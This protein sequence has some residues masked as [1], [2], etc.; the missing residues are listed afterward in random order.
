MLDD[1]EFAKL[2]FDTRKTYVE[3]GIAEASRFIAERA[4]GWTPQKWRQFGAAAQQARQ[5]VSES[6]TAGET[7]KRY[8]GVAG[9][10][11]KDLPAIIGT[12]VVGLSPVLP[13]GNGGL[14]GQVPGETLGPALGRNIVGLA[15]SGAAMLSDAEQPMVKQIDTLKQQID[16]GEFLTHKKGF[17]GWM[18]EQNAAVREKQKAFYQNEDWADQNSLLGS[19]ENVKLMQDYL[20][21]RSPQ[22]W[23]ALQDNLLRTPFRAKLQADQQALEN[24]TKLGRALAPEARPLISEAADPAELLPGMLAVK[25]GV[26]IAT[27]GASAGSRA[28]D[29][30]KGIA[31]EMLGEQVSATIDNPYLSAAER[32]QVAKDSLAG[33]L[34]LMGVGAGAKAAVQ[35]LSPSTINSPPST[36]DPLSPNQTPAPTGTPQTPGAT[37]GAAPLAGAAGPVPSTLSRI[38]QESLVPDLPEDTGALTAEEVA[39]LEGQQGQ[40]VNG[41]ELSRQPSRVPA[42]AD[43]PLRA[44]MTESGDVINDLRIPRSPEA[45]AESQRLENERQSQIARLRM[46][47]N[48]AQGMPVIPDSPRGDKDI[49][50]FAN[51]NPIYLPP[52]FSEQRNLPEYE[53]LKG[54]KLPQY[55]RQFIA[56]GKRGGN[57]GDVA[58]RA[59]DLGFIAEPTADAYFNALNEGIDARKQYRAQFATREKAL[60]TEEKQVVAFDKSQTKLAKQPDAQEVPFED[61]LPGDQMTIDGEQAVVKNVE[62]NEDGYLTNV[63]IEDGKRFGLMQFDPQSRGGIL[64][65]EYQPRAARNQ[66]A[67]N[68][69]APELQPPATSPFESLLQGTESTRPLNVGET[70]KAQNA[71]PLGELMGA[72]QA[73][74]AERA[75]GK[76][77]L[78]RS[79][80]QPGIDKRAD[81]PESLFTYDARPIQD[82]SAGERDTL[83]VLRGLKE[84]QGHVITP[85]NVRLRSRPES[86]PRRQDTRAVSAYGWSGAFAKAFSKSVLFYDGP[87]EL[88]GAVAEGQRNIIAINVNGT[89]PLLYTLGHEL[90]HSMRAQNS[91]LYNA[92]AAEVLA[93]GQNLDAYRAKM[94][95]LGYKTK[96]EINEE[97]VADF[98]GSQF[99][100]P[101]FLNQ[102]AEDKPGL[103]ARFARYVTKFINSLLGKVGTISRD[104][105]PHFKD[106]LEALRAKLVTALKEYAASGQFPDNPMGDTQGTALNASRAMNPFTPSDAPGWMRTLFKVPSVG[107]FRVQNLSVRKLLTGSALP[108]AMAEVVVA[109]DRD[110]KSIEYAAATLANDLEQAMQKH[111]AAT[112][113]T[114]QQVNDLVTNVLQGALPLTIVLDPELRTAIRRARNLLDSL[115]TAVAGATTGQMGQTILANLGSW[116]RRSYAAFDPAAGWSYDEL[117][118]AAAKGRKVAGEP[119]SKILN[120][121]RRYLRSQTPGL[122]LGELEAQMRQLMDRNLWEEALIGSGAGVRK[123]VTSLMKRKDIAPE[124]RALM[125]EERN[126]VKKLIGSAKWQAQ[127]IA[128]HENQQKIRDVGLQLGMFSPSQTGRFTEELGEDRSTSGFA[129]NGQKI[130]TTPELRRA[131]GQTTGVLATDDLGSN[132]LK[133]IYWLGGQAK[134]NKVA[135]NPDS[136]MV[137]LLGNFTGLAMTGGLSPFA[138]L[139]LFQNSRK[140]IELMRAGKKQAAAG[141]QQQ[142]QNDLMRQMM[143]KLTAAGVADSSMNAQL[144]EDALN[145]N[146][147]QFIERHD[148]WNGAVGAVKLAVVGQALAKPFGATGRVVGGVVGGVA[149][150]AIGN[151]RVQNVQEA[152]AKWTM[153]NPDRFGKIVEFLDNHTTLIASGMTPD[154]AFAKAT[155][156]TLNTMPDYSKLPAV[157]RQFSRLGVV[158]SFI[159]FQWEVYRNSFHNAK[160]IA[161]ELGSGNPALMEKGVRRLLGMSAVYALALGG[162]QALLG[163]DAGDDE[164]DEAYRRAL[165]KPW[166]KYSR[167]AYSR[168]DTEKA[169]FYN[170][171]Y[172]LPQVTLTEII[173]AAAEG[174]TF[175]GALEQA[176]GV[177]QKQFAE[178][179]IHADPLLALLFNFDKGGQKATSEE[180]YRAA[181]ERL[182]EVLAPMT[183]GAADK[184][185]RILRS[186]EVLNQPRWDREFSVAEEMKRLIGIRQATYSHDRRIAGRL[187]EFNSRKRDITATAAQTYGETG[188]AKADVWGKQQQQQAAQRATERLT[189]L[190]AE[191][192]QF[193]KDL[194]TLGFKPTQIE[195]FR[196]DAG[197]SP[198]WKPYGITA[199]GIKQQ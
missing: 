162:L 60:A 21:T 64:V 140:A 51:E 119:A 17:Q 182:A 16:Q 131:L 79:T 98:V 91:D 157:L 187:S 2:P 73:G 170:T 126:P 13:D 72:K 48:K 76:M 111:S 177:L 121:A 92:L 100:E 54:A 29:A 74:E 19:A 151:E 128:K 141:T 77:S 80:A 135:L 106:N 81:A 189:A 78:S 28:L 8:A 23:A 165:G 103:F 136:W 171:S 149:G 9:Q 147:V 156:K 39:D 124:I 168:L 192:D 18:D 127:F 188:K 65:D 125:G 148:V 123:D 107:A 27:K 89:D 159:A 75:Q 26:Q 11:I 113:Q 133:M 14:T 150:Y 161:E 36:N 70:A 63:V 166:E 44:P 164:K 185:E 83:R 12:G 144:V 41:Q 24:D 116:M 97:M 190:K 173:R 61:V 58:Q 42:F 86:G 158:G 160:Y 153:Q 40:E 50:D 82:L 52:G 7:V 118:K 145:K 84:H 34:G 180:G 10:T 35:A 105:R 66:T 55:W 6:E 67:S 146:L 195:R 38:A 199:E 129:L 30:A 94:V 114:Q 93:G 155:T 71:D 68:D 184:F 110:K 104:I 1:P 99:L 143:A 175:A 176:G 31:G 196:K 134:L 138:P 109:A 130:Y 186:R 88:N 181:L 120:D 117:T 142:V 5:F 167:L 96:A 95:G 59:F 47:D 179:G 57:P 139:R 198:N 69:F 194:G 132:F 25:K 137:N 154:A 178:S 172:L 37:P 87:N 20:T 49:L 174:K 112:G 122:T 85:V 46:I 169:S 62:F 197:T 45:I 108:K 56:S 90:T 102:L 115:S 4:G 191:Y 53:K 193:T 183:P 101:D 15:A 3:K 32:L 152:I 43:D 163:N 22:S 33:S